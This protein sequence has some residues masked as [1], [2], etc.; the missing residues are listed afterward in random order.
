MAVISNPT[1]QML[2]EAEDAYQAL[3]C[4]RSARVIVDQGGERVEFTAANRPALA[5]Y[6]QSL[7]A[8]LGVV[9]LGGVP[10]TRG[11]LGF[12]F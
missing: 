11:P 5:A 9:P 6:I 4:G 2:K 1:M 12:I 7:Q 10:A 3:L 8:A